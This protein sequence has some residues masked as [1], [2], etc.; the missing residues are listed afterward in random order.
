M[1]GPYVY[2]IDCESL[3]ICEQ[4]W[5]V[6]AGV[7]NIEPLQKA[8]EAIDGFV[9][10]EAADFIINNVLGQTLGMPIEFAEKL[11]GGDST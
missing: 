3:F 5:K 8:A 4:N 7:R 2:S 6:P 10:S 1:G 9:A 11:P